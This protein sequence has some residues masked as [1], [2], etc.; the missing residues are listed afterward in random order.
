[1]TTL[2]RMLHGAL[3]PRSG[4]VSV[5]GRPI[6]DLSPREL[7][8]EVAVVVQELQTETTATVGEAALLGRLPHLRGFA[9]PDDEDH[10]IT[11]DALERVGVGHLG[12]RGFATLSGVEQQR[13]LIARAVAQ[14]ATHLLLDEP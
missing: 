13:V 2:L 4:M 9:G 11:A 12:R 14:Q 3:E 5:D 10:A 7:A 1:K 8:R 6:R